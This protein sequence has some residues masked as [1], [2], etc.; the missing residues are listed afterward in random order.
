VTASW[1]SLLETEIQS[2]AQVL[3]SE[4]SNQIL[5]RSEMDQALDLMEVL[6]SDMVA[7][8]QAGLTSER[9]GIM[10]RTFYS[11]LVNS[12]DTLLDQLQDP[13]LR[14]FVRKE[15]SKKLLEAYRLVPPSPSSCDPLSRCRF[16]E[17]SPIP[18]TVTRAQR[19]C[20]HTPSTRSRCSWAAPRNRSEKSLGGREVSQTLLTWSAPPRSLF[21][22]E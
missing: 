11:S 19:V 10:I 3:I 21:T 20:C 14:E 12:N 8:E 18:K 1:V 2:W 6:P 13:E 16:I 15:S 5:Q 9:L 4:N 22:E 17:R 7:S